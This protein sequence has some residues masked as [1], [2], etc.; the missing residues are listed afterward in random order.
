MLQKLVACTC[1]LLGSTAVFAQDKL[2][3][4]D[5]TI[6]QAVDHYIDAR[7]TAAKVSPA[8]PADDAAILR[9]LT[10]DLNGRVPTLSEADDYLKSTDP[11]RKTKLVDRLLASPAFSRHGAQTFLAFMQYA[12]GRPRKGGGKG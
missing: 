10:L 8:P 9:R 5:R 6:E 1:L 11:D 3:P 12:E 2:L 7:L 4:A